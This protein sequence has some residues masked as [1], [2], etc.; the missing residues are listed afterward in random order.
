MFAYGIGRDIILNPD[1][2]QSMFFERLL[3]PYVE[4]YGELLF[5]DYPQSN[6]K[7]N[8]YL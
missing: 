4:M 8:Y 7:L 6:S 1:T 5:F 3:V 2:D